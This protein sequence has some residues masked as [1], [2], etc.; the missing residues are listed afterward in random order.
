MQEHEPLC[1]HFFPFSHLQNEE[2]LRSTEVHERADAYSGIAMAR[3]RQYPDNWMA[4]HDPP[5]HSSVR[6][7]VPDRY[8][9]SFSSL[10]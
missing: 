4:C 5:S 1:Y 6:T 2:S 10:R 3:A 9:R 7:G 8:T